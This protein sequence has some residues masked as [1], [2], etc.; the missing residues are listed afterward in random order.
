MT[1]FLVRRI[2]VMIPL[3][4]LV[5]FAVFM[6]ISLMPGDVARAIAG[7]E[8]SQSDIERVTAEYHLDRPIIVQYGYWIADTVQLDLGESRYTRVPVSESIADALPVTV[9]LV[10]T[11]S[12]IA[13]VVGVPLGAVAGIRPG[14]PYD[15]VSRIG[16]GAALAMPNFVLAILLL[17]GVGVKLGW[18]PLLGYEKFTESPTGW[19]TYIILPASTLALHFG[20]ILFRQVRAGMID[21]LDS[22]YIRTA[23]ARGGRPLGV[24]GKHGLKNGSMP[25]LTVFG[26]QFAAL[27][28]GTV[29]VEQIYSLPGLG[30][31]LLQA[32]KGRDLPAIQGCILVFVVAQALTSL[33]IDVAYGFLNPKMRVAR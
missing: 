12:A 19:L 16:S 23:W 30:P 24:I 29:I 3:L 22:P 25:A 13:V 21:T 27:L 20:A 2:A 11:A 1:R 8:A 28:G 14:G 4:V 18:L 7:Q 5:S 10:L 31:Y 17:L 33:L 15:V 32:I 26:V 6:L 9:G